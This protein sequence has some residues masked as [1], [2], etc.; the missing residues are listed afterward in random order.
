M[1]DFEEQKYFGC[2]KLGWGNGSLGNFVNSL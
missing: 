2:V 1:L